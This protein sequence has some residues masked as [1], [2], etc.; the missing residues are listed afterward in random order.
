[1]QLH[2]VDVTAVVGGVG[3]PVS[4]DVLVCRNPAHPHHAVSDQ[5]KLEADWWWQRDCGGKKH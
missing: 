1:M 3:D 5:W 2:L 4:R